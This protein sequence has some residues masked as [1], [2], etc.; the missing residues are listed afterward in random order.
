MPREV[1]ILEATRKLYKRLD[2]LAKVIKTSGEGEP[3]LVGSVLGVSLNIEC[4][5][6]GEKP[7]PLQIHRLKEWARSGAI[8]GWTDDGKTFTLIDQDANITEGATFE[9]LV[10]WIHSRTNLH[11]HLTGDDLLAVLPVD[12]LPEELRDAKAEAAATDPYFSM[13]EVNNGLRAVKDYC[14]KRGIYGQDIVDVFNSGMIQTMI[15]SGDLSR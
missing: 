15:D 8:A 4:K 11:A 7:E 13:R 14:N 10:V 2:S 1:Q 5:Q 12:T 6:P 3:D 9:T